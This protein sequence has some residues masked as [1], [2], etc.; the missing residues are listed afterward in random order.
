MQF[1]TKTDAFMT[2]T[3]AIIQSQAESIQNLETKVGQLASAIN[4]RPHDDGDK[5]DQGNTSSNQVQDKE[6]KQE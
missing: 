3:N 4:N 5:L 6:I 2:R 1:M